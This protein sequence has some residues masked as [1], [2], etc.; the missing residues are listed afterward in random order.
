MKSVPKFMRGVF[1]GAIKTS[2][3]A[4]LR[5]RERNDIEVETR[6]GSAPHPATTRGY[7]PARTSE[8][9]SGQVQRGRMGSPLG[10]VGG[11]FQARQCCKK[12]TQTEG[13]RTNSRAGLV[14]AGIGLGGEVVPSSGSRQ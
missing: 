3:Q 10:V 6:S 14:V 11:V 8:G 4:I 12:S 13:Q 5:G 1:R 7:C 2:L 9:E